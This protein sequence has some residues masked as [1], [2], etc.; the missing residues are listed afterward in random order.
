MKRISLL[1]N[2]E[3]GYS[4]L[5]V[6]L[7]IILVTGIGV[8]LLTV[9]ANSLKTSTNERKDQSIF[10]IAEAGLN[11]EKAQ[12]IT[13]I[14]QGYRNAQ[15]T[16]ASLPKKE[17]TEDKFNSLYENAVKSA[18]QTYLSSEKKPLLKE[19]F[20]SKQFDQQPIAEIAIQLD[21]TNPRKYS[22]TSKGYFESSPSNFRTL[23]QNIEIVLEANSSNVPPD[24]DYPHPFV[25]EFTVHTKG[26]ISLSGSATIDG[27][28]ATE[29]GNYSI[30]GGSSITGTTNKSNYP[31]ATVLP[32]F[33]NEEFTKEDWDKLKPPA[34]LEVVHSD[35]QKALI[36]NN[37]D[38]L[39]TNYIT[40]NSTL[41]LSNSTHFK[42]FAVNES[43][44][45]TIDVGDTDKH[46][47]IDNLDI[48]E[49]H[50][51]V[52]GTGKL[53]IYV[54]NSIKINGS[55][56]KMGDANQVNF[57]YNGR[58]DLNI[59][60]NTQATASLYSNSTEANLSFT[61]STGFSGNIYT[62]A[63]SVKLSGASN[64]NGQYI[65]APFAKVELSGS[66]SIKGALLADSLYADGGTSV[67]FVES[68]IKPPD[69][70]YVDYGDPIKLFKEDAMLEK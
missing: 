24:P 32:K 11:Y 37:G 57:F 58:T 49:G 36:I 19:N 21:P 34:N 14:N 59:S 4:L 47:Y 52:V 42:R 31:G 8:G 6:F 7:T 53:N 22:L 65:I 40:N 33:P 66:G 2:N 13:R 68:I 55:F 69:T 54:K 25:P 44:I 20:F 23:N 18:I 17:K 51:K 43:N 15:S 48:I 1:R 67:T 12:I 41:K 64:S 30:T 10:Y 3:N 9:S 45:V 50:I 29:N 56:N 28:A 27:N 38:F 39:A 63:K 16:Y 70:G 46:L 62:N 5:V 35:G 61:G 60:G 26:D